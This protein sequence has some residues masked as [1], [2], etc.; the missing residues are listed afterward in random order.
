[1]LDIGVYNALLS[2]VSS[3][4]FTRES[5][6]MASGITHPCVDYVSQSP[7]SIYVINHY[8]CLELPTLNQ[9]GTFLLKKHFPVVLYNTRKMASILS[10]DELVE[11]IGIS[12][13]R[14]AD[15]VYDPWVVFATPS[16]KQGEFSLNVW[17][18]RNF[19]QA[20]ALFQARCDIMRQNDGPDPYLI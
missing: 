17:M 13:H 5:I 8:A 1:M 2:R 14:L 19:H 18:R 10:E 6:S 20:E 16:G 12:H 3:G 11:T 7:F 4:A 15:N 9:Y